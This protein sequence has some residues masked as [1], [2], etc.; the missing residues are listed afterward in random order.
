MEVML[1]KDKELKRTIEALLSTYDGRLSLASTKLNEVTKEMRA[2]ASQ[3]NSL[4]SE[5]DR[6]MERI[7]AYSAESLQ[8]KEELKLSQS[9]LSEA[10]GKIIRLSGIGSQLYIR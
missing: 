4:K 9:K 8:N 6:L 7:K 3:N 10:E 5:N 1:R 2:Q